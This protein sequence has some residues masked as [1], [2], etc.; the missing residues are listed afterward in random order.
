MTALRFSL[1]RLLAAIV[2]IAAALAMLVSASSLWAHVCSA[3]FVFVMLVAVLAIP[4]RRGAARAFWLGFAILGWGFLLYG[5]YLA[6][7]PATDVLVR[8]HR[9]V[10]RFE[11]PTLSHATPVQITARGTLRVNDEEVAREQV[12]DFL[13]AELRRSGHHRVRVYIDPELED[14]DLRHSLYASVARAVDGNT[15]NVSLDN[16]IPSTPDVPALQDFLHIGHQLCNL[17]FALLGAL[18][19]RVLYLTQ[20][21]KP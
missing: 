3:L 21:R 13:S 20:E 7:P 19:G 6:S 10:R 11:P 14:D 15:L 4:Y 8:L 2:L 1:A 18:A 5:K 9:L 16:Q 17:L 12:A